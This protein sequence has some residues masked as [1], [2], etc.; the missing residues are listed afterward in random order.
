MG[1]PPLLQV[2]LVEDHEALRKTILELLQRAGYACVAVDNGI[3]AL[4]ELKRRYFDLVLTD[5]KME[6]ID[7]IELLARVKKQWPATEVIIITAFGTISKGVEAMKLGA[8]D[9]ITKPFDHD[10]LLE[11]LSW[12]EESHATDRNAQ[13]FQSLRAREEF[14]AIVGQSDRMVATLATV[15]RIA[16]TEATVII[17]GE[18]GTGKELIAQ[19]IHAMSRRRSAP[20]VT[21]NCGTIAENLQESELFGHAKGAFTDAKSEKK[22]LLE[23]AHGGTVFLDEIAETSITTQV[24]LLRFLQ[25]KEIRRVGDNTTR[26]VDVRMVAATNK[27]LKELVAQGRFRDD[28]F[29][30]LNVISVEVPPLRER[31]EDIPLLIEHFINK[32]AHINCKPVKKVSRRAS[33]MLVNYDWP[34]N[35]RELENVIHRAVALSDAE[36]ITPDLLA[37]EIGLTSPSESVHS[38][39][40][41][42]ADIETE[43]I[44]KTLKRLNGSKKDTARE[45]GISKTTLWRKL[46]EIPEATKADYLS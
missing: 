6:P 31:K 21:I 3:D 23:M 11:K 14:S 36:E 22:G 32:Y 15:A 16:P 34:G 44:L 4:Q 24:K 28:L 33:A 12:L 20:F 39:T 19:S 7:G 38:G 46:K 42:L 10:E 5:Y 41:K 8:Y 27:D 2:L 30:R 17:Y 26:A 18:S 35:V 1:R 29:Y 37:R 9:Y 25:E 40:T 13:A 43:V 45:L